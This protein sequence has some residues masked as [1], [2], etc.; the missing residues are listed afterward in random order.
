[1][2]IAYLSL[3]SQTLESSVD[4]RPFPVHL[5]I[6]I[7]PQ[8][9]TKQHKMAE[10]AEPSIN[11]KKVQF[12]AD[13]PSCDG[14]KAREAEKE[15]ASKDVEDA[16]Q[17]PVPTPSPP[18]VSPSPAPPI[19]QWSSEDRTRLGRKRN[20]E[21]VFRPLKLKFKVKELEE[22]YRNYVYRQQQNLLFTACLI[23]VALSI[24][25]IMAFLINAKV[26]KEGW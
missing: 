21:W 20:S 8:S 11:Q 24:M 22:L 18:T 15:K 3:A 1:M 4:L 12:N 26:R 6:S 9:A 25:V 2:I 14:V 5:R 19:E 16:L 7:R 13:S 17:I 10:V 23:L